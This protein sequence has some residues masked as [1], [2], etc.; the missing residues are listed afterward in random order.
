MQ[1]TMH[2]TRL[3]WPSRL[4]MWLVLC[5]VGLLTLVAAAPQA[6]AATWIAGNGNYSVRTNWSPANVT[7]GRAAF[8]RACLKMT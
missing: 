3:N 2:T 4:P 8:F 5:V 6:T 7:T 1:E